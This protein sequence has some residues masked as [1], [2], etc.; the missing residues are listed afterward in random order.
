MSNNT[1]NKPQYAT[2]WHTCVRCGCLWPDRALRILKRHDELL[3]IKE[4]V[5]AC[6][7][8]KQCAVYKEYR[9]AEFKRESDAVLKAISARPVRSR[10]RAS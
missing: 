3:N 9:D 7:D 8:E 1:P 10:K 2:D 5:H 4:T 6:R